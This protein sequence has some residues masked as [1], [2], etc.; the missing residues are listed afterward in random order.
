[1]IDAEYDVIR[2]LNHPSVSVS[3]REFHWLIFDFGID[4]TV[5]AFFLMLQMI[6]LIFNCYVG[7]NKYQRNIWVIGF[8]FFATIISEGIK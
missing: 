3:Y 6:L 1:M 2:L 7:C 5:I 4:N 8:V